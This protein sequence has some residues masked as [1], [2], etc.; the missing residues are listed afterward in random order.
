MHLAL[1]HHS[2]DDTFA[3]SKK[4]EI[5]AM[6]QLQLR[7]QIVSDLFKLGA[8]SQLL[9]VNHAGRTPQDGDVSTDL[10]SF[11]EYLTVNNLSPLR[12]ED[13]MVAGKVPGFKFG[14]RGLNASDF[15][16]SMHED[17][18]FEMFGGDTTE[19]E[20]LSAKGSHHWKILR[21]RTFTW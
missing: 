12:E 17:E 19:S 1:M 15:G 21:A 6:Q 5:Q 3:C 9:S 13:P 11:A 14:A 7:K 8:K 10:G 16:E 4:D 18:A 20:I 2:D